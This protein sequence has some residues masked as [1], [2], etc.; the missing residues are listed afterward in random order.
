ML[1]RRLIS[2]LIFLPFIYSGLFSSGG[3]FF[4]WYLE[5]TEVLLHKWQTPCCRITS[6][7]VLS[8]SLLSLAW[9]GAE[10]IYLVLCI[11]ME[12]FSQELID[13]IPSQS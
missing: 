9:V 6:M 5:R 10:T 3:M 7:K 12:T 1:S 13:Y 4:L 8:C 11:L 2:Q